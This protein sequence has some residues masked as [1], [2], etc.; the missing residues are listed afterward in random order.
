M[1][2]RNFKNS[3][4]VVTGAAGNLGTAFCERFGK[5]GAK[6]IALDLNADDVEKLTKEL[7]N[8]GIET[9]GQACDITNA[10]ACEAAVKAG[11]KHFG[12]IDHLIN[13]AGITHIERYRKMD[14]NKNIVRKVMEV[15]FFGSVNATEACLDDIVWNKGMVLTV[16]SVAGFAPLIGRTAYSASKH[17]LHGFFESLRAELADD[18]VQCMMICPSFISPNEPKDSEKVDASEKGSIYQ[19]KKLVGKE[20]TATMAAE[21]VYNA[22]VANKPLITVGKISKQSYLLTRVAPNLYENIMRKRLKD[23][24]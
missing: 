7:N 23:E 22:A 12:R 20:V 8:K 11:K 3:V 17:A 15:N 5:E 24:G 9:W 10:T 4:I 1:T 16:S 21:S 2:K 19:P 18:G 13:N 6:I 14:K